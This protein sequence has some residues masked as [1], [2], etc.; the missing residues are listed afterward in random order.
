MREETHR[1]GVVVDAIRQTNL[2]QTFGLEIVRLRNRTSE[3]D[4]KNGIKPFSV[5]VKL[6]HIVSTEV[7]VIVY[8][9]AFTGCL[10]AFL[11]TSFV[12][13][14]VMKVVCASHDDLVREV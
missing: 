6:Q 1:V 11:V 14:G 5:H 12:F 9:G 10:Y 2:F 3:S 7:D 8:S 4:V 13:F